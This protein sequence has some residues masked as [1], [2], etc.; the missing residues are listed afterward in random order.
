MSSYGYMFGE[1]DE[2][3]VVPRPLHKKGEPEFKKQKEDFRVSGFA[4][5]QT[6]NSLQTSYAIYNAVHVILAAYENNDITSF[7]EQTFRR[8]SQRDH[9]YIK[10]DPEILIYDSIDTST[11]KIYIEQRINVS[12]LLLARA[13]QL[14][15]T[16]EIVPNVYSKRTKFLTVSAR[17]YYGE[18]AVLAQS[19]D[20][21][22]YLPTEDAK[23][24]AAFM[25]QLGAKSPA[26]VCEED[27]LETASSNLLQFIESNRSKIND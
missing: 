27:F 14:E 18:T 2:S 15:Y 5:V 13:L 10:I 4:P 7:G 20:I 16:F 11:L 21:Q 19:F 6:P 9:E 1:E 26:E 8:I 25:E 12:Q 24:I 22:D 17:P 23:L 3:F